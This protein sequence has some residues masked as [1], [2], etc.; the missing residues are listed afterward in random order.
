MTRTDQA[1]DIR[2]AALSMWG[3]FCRRLLPGT[4]RRM[5]LWKGIPRGWLPELTE[6]VQQELA[7]DAI[8]CAGEIVELLPMQRHR[9][10]M[11][12]AARW[13]HHH[14]LTHRGEPA[15]PEEPLAPAE[16]PTDQ[17]P[18]L[19]QVVVLGNGRTNVA[20]TAAALGHGRREVRR[21]ATR[22]AELAG[23]D[24]AYHAFWRRRTAEAL[25]GLAADLLRERGHLWLVARPRPAPAP[26]HRLRRLRR[27]VPRFVV[28]PSTAVE[29]SILRRWTKNPDLGAAAPRQLL[30]DAVK[31]APQHAAA[32]LWLFEACIGDGELGRAA[33]ALRSARRLAEPDRT[34]VLLARA[35]LLEMRGRWPAASALLQR[36]AR[37]WPH[38]QPLQRWCQRLIT[39]W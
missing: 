1:E 27:L 31:L 5:S 20:A 26:A 4:L 32:W 16:L 30:E 21:Q 33:I 36:A 24:G 23:R 12:L 18:P 14:W 13:I 29:R 10:W 8:E 28:Q 9:R 2:T 25:T 34:P 37:R 35:R 11:R 7:V 15:P 38:D 3:T 19:P 6:D 39:P 22:W 17:L